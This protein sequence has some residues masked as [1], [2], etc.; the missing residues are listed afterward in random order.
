MEKDYRKYRWFFTSSD[1]VVIGGKSAEQNEEIMKKHSESREDYVVMHTSAPGSPFTLIK[2]PNK[3]DLDEM[4]IFT[5]CFSQQWKK[6]NDSA[7]VDIF[8][9]EQVNK[10]KK[11]KTGTFGV[12]GKIQ[13]KKVKLELSL[14][15]QKGKLRAVPRMT[16]KKPFVILTPGPLSKEQ[17]VEQLVKI[18]KNKFNYIMSKD[19]I[20][21]ALP[22][23][24]ISIK[25]VK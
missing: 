7:E 11:M 5:A 16:V 1:N 23:K 4:A 24:D 2:S 17:A 14:D 9:I 15:F 18:I 22:A 21:A 25:E 12:M 13:R 20:M 19:E 10:D 6:N 8:T 3:K